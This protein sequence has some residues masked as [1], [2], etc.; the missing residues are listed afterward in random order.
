MAL[1]A[2]PAAAQSFPELTGRVV[3]QA[4]IIPPAEEASLTAQLEQLEKASGHQLVVATVAS[5]EGHDVGDY[6]YRLGRAWGIGGKEANDGVVF[7]IAPHDRRMN[8]SVGYGLEP[9]LTDALSGRVIRDVVTPKFKADA[10]PGGIQAGVDAI[11]EQIQLPPEEAATPVQAA[12]AEK[13]DVRR[14]GQ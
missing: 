3:D 8:I 13:E 11:D 4:D 14:E 5:L 9:I 1:V 2:S 12:A 7:L 6:G 10:Y